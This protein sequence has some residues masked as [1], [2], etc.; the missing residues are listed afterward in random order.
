MLVQ[1]I[2][3]GLPALYRLGFS[4]IQMILTGIIQNLP[5][6]ISAGLQILGMLAQGIATGLPQLLA[7]A[8]QLIPLV[9][10][11]IASGLPSLITSGI[12]IILMILSGLISAIPTLIG[13]IP[14]L[15]SGVVDAVTSID[16]LDVG[17][18]LVNSIKD[19]FVSGFSSLVDTAKGLW[20]DFT[21]WLFGEDD[22]PDTTPVAGTATAIENDIP[23]VGD[24]S[25]QRK[26]GTFHT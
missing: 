2:V 18:N 21:G 26:P 4:L 9:L 7:Q 23:K 25:R 16:W 10:Q 15:F 3:T 17:S 6:V 20:D 24:S 12:Q 5:S 22:V 1:G 19:G 11:A 8:L 13:M 14:E